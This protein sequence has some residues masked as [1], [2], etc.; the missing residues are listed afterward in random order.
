MRDEPTDSQL[1]G[2]QPQTQTPTRSHPDVPILIQFADGRF[3]IDPGVLKQIA[4]AVVD[5]IEARYWGRG[6]TEK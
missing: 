1:Y 3:V 4:M 5:E 6:C 2:T